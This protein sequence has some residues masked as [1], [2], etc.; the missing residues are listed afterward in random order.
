MKDNLIFGVRE[1]P[2]AFKSKAGHE[3]TILSREAWL[4]S[5]RRCDF[6]LEFENGVK[7]LVE[8]ADK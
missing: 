4:S 5:D 3:D 7:L 6:W 2:E 8:M 1:R